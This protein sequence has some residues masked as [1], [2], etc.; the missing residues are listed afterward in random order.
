MKT[1]VWDVSVSAD[2]CV[3]N[4]LPREDVY[5][6]DCPV[7]GEASRGAAFSVETELL[8]KVVDS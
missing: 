2:V 4:K 6:S 7:V 8:G 3:E 1:L 5:G